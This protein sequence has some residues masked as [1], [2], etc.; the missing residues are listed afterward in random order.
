MYHHNRGSKD[1]TTSNVHSPATHLTARDAL[2]PG[3]ACTGTTLPSNWSRS[4]LVICAQATD[5]GEARTWSRPLQNQHCLWHVVCN[6]P[7]HQMSVPRHRR[8]PCS[9]AGPWRPALPSQQYRCDNRPKSVTKGDLN[10]PI[11]NLLYRLSPEHAPGSGTHLTMGIEHKGGG[12]VPIRPR[13]TLFT[14]WIP[15]AQ[16]RA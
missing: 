11:S 15:T 16:D 10:R 2:G 4:S 8:C 7:E 5:G 1:Q 9:T 14:P 12:A 13:S 3:G 6:I